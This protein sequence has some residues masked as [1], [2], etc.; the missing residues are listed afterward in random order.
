MARCLARLAK[1][2]LCCTNLS[3]VKGAWSSI[4]VD[5]KTEEGKE[6]ATLLR[7]GA[8]YRFL[9]AQR[10]VGAQALLEAILAD[11][12]SFPWV[13]VAAENLKLGEPL[14]SAAVVACGP[15]RDAALRALA[16][17][18]VCAWL[19][20]EPHGTTP[21]ISVS[22]PRACQLGDRDAFPSSREVT[23]FYCHLRTP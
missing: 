14:I 23:Q 5:E 20:L 22:V 2:V 3:F 13:Q 16:P 19:R 15:A 17:L 9:D 21:E 11:T 12:M 1:T 18:I 6:F 7:C 4:T 8:S 10:R